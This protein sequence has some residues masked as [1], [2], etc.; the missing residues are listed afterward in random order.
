[1]TRDG[2]DEVA[3]GAPVAVGGA[4]NLT[5]SQSPQDKPVTAPLMAMAPPAPVMARIQ[6]G[7]QPLATGPAASA[8]Q[9]QAV[10]Q[11]KSQ[12]RIFASIPL[13]TF[14]AANSPEHGTRQDKATSKVAAPASVMNNTLQTEA[15]GGGGFPGG[16]GGFGGN[17]PE[18]LDTWQ[19]TLAAAMQ[20]PL[21]GDTTGEQQANQALMAAK[22]S[23]ALDDLRAR[24]EARRSQSPKD[25]VTGRMLAAVYDYGFS[26]E[27][28]LHERRRVANLDGAVGEDWYT[29]AQAEERAGNTQAARAAYRRAL[30]C[31]VPPSPFHA[32]LAR[33]RS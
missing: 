29:L 9:G 23:G 20:P 21:W 5:P 19:A 30:E 10:P 4:N 1:M 32:S 31:P 3:P 18:G 15:M 24:L 17:V 13:T 11:A 8:R 2:Q 28:A 26:H 6:N 12:G 14:R 25:L 33:L 16:G 22:E 7:P 27:S